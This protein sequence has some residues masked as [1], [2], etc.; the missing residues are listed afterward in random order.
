MT[1]YYTQKHH[2]I[3]EEVVE[4]DEEYESLQF[5]FDEHLPRDPDLPPEERYIMEFEENME[6]AAAA[7]EIIRYCIDT[8]YFKDAYRDAL[9]QHQEACEAM[10]WYLTSSR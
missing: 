1:A 5:Q 9:R 8:C 6:R 10:W 3:T 2:D 7:D 4:D